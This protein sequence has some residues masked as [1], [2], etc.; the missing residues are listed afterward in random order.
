[1]AQTPPAVPDAAVEVYVTQGID[2]SHNVAL[3]LTT[4]NSSYVIALPPDVA[5]QLSESLPP[6]LVTAAGDADKLNNTPKL[7]LPTVAEQHIVNHKRR[8]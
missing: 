1:M 4:L 5:R 3:R 8:H 6:L 7:A 2:K